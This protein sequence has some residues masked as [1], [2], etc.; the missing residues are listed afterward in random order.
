MALE[1][2]GVRGANSRAG[3]QLGE[4]RRSPSRM[5]TT[6]APLLPFEEHTS[7]DPTGERRCGAHGC[8]Q[9]RGMAPLALRLNWDKVFFPFLFLIVFPRRMPQDDMCQGLRQVPV[10]SVT[11]A[12]S[13][14]AVP[15]P[16]PSANQAPGGH[17]E[18]K[19]A[20]EPPH[21]LTPSPPPLS[22]TLDFRHRPLE[23]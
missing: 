14:H 16:P 6:S 21:P 1:Q 19:E 8:W 18:M 4:A 11:G 5:K 17:Q 2:G 9:L 15:R 13:E 12:F 20:E 3:L 22:P 7:Q 23:L 10:A